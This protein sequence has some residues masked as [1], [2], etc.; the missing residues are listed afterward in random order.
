MQI[1]LIQSYVLP[2]L[3]HSDSFNPSSLVAIK[4]MKEKWEEEK[5]ERRR[6]VDDEASCLLD[7]KPRLEAI[8][9]YLDDTIMHHQRRLIFRYQ[10]SIFFFGKKNVEY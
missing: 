1:R 10:N 7:V 9:A 5:K 2:I 3:D 6:N 4:T 8:M